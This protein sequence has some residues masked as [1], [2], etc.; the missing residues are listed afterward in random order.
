M[1]RSDDDTRRVYLARHFAQ[2]QSQLSWM[3]RSD[4]ISKRSL[5]PEQAK[6]QSQLSWMSRSDAVA[7]AGPG[8]VRRVSIPV[9]VD[10][11][12]RPAFGV[13]GYPSKFASAEQT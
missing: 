9:V 11:S 13:M 5:T 8:P 12:F 1:S 4:A 10:E 6:S 7:R 2:S 3:S